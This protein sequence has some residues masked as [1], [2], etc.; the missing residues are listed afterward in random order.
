M[1]YS[2]VVTLFIY[3]LSMGLLKTY[4]GELIL[5]ALLSLVY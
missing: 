1:I 3:V 2:E 5:K 4:F